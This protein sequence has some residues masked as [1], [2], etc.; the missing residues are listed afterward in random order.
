MDYSG[1]YPKVIAVDAQP[2]SSRRCDDSGQPRS[3]EQQQ[4]MYM[5]TDKGCGMT[6]VFGGQV[7]TM[8]I[9]PHPEKLEKP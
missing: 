5:Y 2:L 7:S 3:A 8:M 4:R 6:V 1:D 9:P